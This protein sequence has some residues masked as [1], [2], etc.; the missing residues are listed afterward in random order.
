MST[1]FAQ[2]LSYLHSNPVQ[3]SQLLHVQSAQSTR[4]SWRYSQTAIKC[5]TVQ[6]N[7]PAQMLKFWVW[8]TS[9]YKCS[10]MYC[11]NMFNTTAMFIYR[12]CYCQ[13]SNILPF[14]FSWGHNITQNALFRGPRSHLDQ[15]V[16]NWVWVSW[17]AGW[18]IHSQTVQRTWAVLQLYSQQSGATASHDGGSS[19]TSVPWTGGTPSGSCPE[20]EESFIVVCCILS[21]A[22][23]TLH[24]TDYCGRYSAQQFHHRH[25]D[26]SHSEFQ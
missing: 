12:C 23:D 1:H 21:A 17:R 3:P 18:G 2:H 6:N 14:H 11:L 26:S 15:K 24:A 5:L 10:Y 7:W 4:K 16:E 25:S 8:I 9:T 13:V 19:H 20:K 22:K